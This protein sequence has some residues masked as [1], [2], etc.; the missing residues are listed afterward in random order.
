MTAQA[1]SIIAPALAFVSAAGIFVAGRF[2]ES[3]AINTAILTE[4]DRLLAAL[5]GHEIWWTVRIAAGDT[6]VPL[7]AFSAPVYN[8]QLANVGRV[9]KRIITEVVWFHGYLNFLNVL[10]ASRRKYGERTK[11]F[12][13]TY[14]KVLRA[15]LR[16]SWT[17]FDR[18]FAKG[19]S[20][21]PH[22]PLPS[23][24]TD[25]D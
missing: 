8:S 24:P 4:I 5:R 12:D 3:Q 19:I 14:Q 1:L 17:A 10:Q 2:L 25:K 20:N 16:R 23:W 9:R 22:A 21:V 11:D 18:E 7:F 15:L 13:V 6:D